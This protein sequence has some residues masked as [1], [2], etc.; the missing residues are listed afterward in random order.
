M[1]LYGPASDSQRS[2]HQN[3]GVYASW[4][5][6]LPDKQ[7]VLGSSPRAPTIRI[8]FTASKQSRDIKSHHKGAS[9]L[10][11][12][13][14]LLLSSAVEQRTV[15]PLVLSSNLRGAANS[16]WFLRKLVSGYKAILPA[17]A[18]AVKQISGVSN[19]KVPLVMEM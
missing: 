5:D 13:F 3:I 1:W 8:L 16:R 12:P 2:H 10:Y 17:R 19:A 14:I 15:N 6:S 18:E 4:L 11:L 7:E 9:S